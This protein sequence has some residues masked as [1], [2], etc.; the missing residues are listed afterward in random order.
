VTLA[1]VSGHS[2][3]VISSNAAFSALLTNPLDT[4]D[5]FNSGV[6]SA[7]TDP[8]S[9]PA[10]M[11]ASR[12]SAPSVTVFEKDLPKKGRALQ[13]LLSPDCPPEPKPK[14]GEV[15]GNDGQW[16]SV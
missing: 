1:G 7:M 9:V 11:P 4:R 12:E 16:I 6:F 13:H 2:G 3:A 10:P 15:M 5:T 14:T 8:F